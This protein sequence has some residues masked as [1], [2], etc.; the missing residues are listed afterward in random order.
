MTSFV[1]QLP[2][3]LISLLRKRGGRSKETS[4]ELVLS[5]PLDSLLEKLLLME[6]MLIRSGLNFSFGC[7]LLLIEI[8][9]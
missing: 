4:A 6:R 9:V 1:S 5:R 7:S 3:M 2:I 8:K